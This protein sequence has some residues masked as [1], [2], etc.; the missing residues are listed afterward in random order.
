[1]QYQVARNWISGGSA[2]MPEMVFRCAATLPAAKVPAVIVVSRLAIASSSLADTVRRPQGG[3]VERAIRGIGSE[4][5]CELSVDGRCAHPH[6]E[7]RWTRD[8]GVEVDRSAHLPREQVE[9][10]LMVGAEDGGHLV[11]GLS[12][13]A[14]LMCVHADR[15][16]RHDPAAL[17][18]GDGDGGEGSTLVLA[19]GRYR[20]GSSAR[21]HGDVF[22]GAPLSGAP[23][24]TG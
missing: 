5:G 24:G 6:L 20:M 10:D 15:G 17:P 1:V 9:R 18:G 11:E 16:C 7:F 8:G 14:V 4:R 3:T 23:D 21:E 19:G 12:L 13:G 2:R 22:A